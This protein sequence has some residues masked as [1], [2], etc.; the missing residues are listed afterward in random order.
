MLHLGRL[1]CTANL[2]GLRKS[3]FQDVTIQAACFKRASE[4]QTHV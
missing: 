2:D 4:I 3:L 1:A